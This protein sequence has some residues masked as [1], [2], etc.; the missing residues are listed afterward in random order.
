MLPNWSTLIVQPASLAP[1]HEQVASLP[2]EI[3]QARCGT[4][5]PFSVAPICRQL[6]QA[7]PQT[8][9]I[10]AEIGTVGGGHAGSIVNEPI[11]D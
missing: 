10:Y 7:R 8:V 4:T 1:A 2:V 6:H 5:P 11:K 3:G 9:V